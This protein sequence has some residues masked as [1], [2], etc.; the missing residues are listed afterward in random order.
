M[1]IDAKHKAGEPLRPDQLFEDILN[2]LV[3]GMEATSYVLSFATYFLLNNPDA[4]AKLEAE[5]REASPFIREEFSHRRIMALP[6]LVCSLGRIIF[7][8]TI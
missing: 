2:Y 7:S 6:Y 8:I 1:T 4:K 3:A 5:L